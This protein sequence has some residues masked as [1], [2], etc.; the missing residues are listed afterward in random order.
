MVGGT[1]FPCCWYALF[2]PAFFFPFSL[3]WF[4][5]IFDPS[6]TPFYSFVP[7]TSSKVVQSLKSSMIQPPCHHKT[8]MSWCTTKASQLTRLAAG[9]K[10]THRSSSCDSWPTQPGVVAKVSSRLT[11]PTRYGLVRTMS[12][13][14]NLCWPLQMRKKRSSWSFS[15]FFTSP[16]HPMAAAVPF[17]APANTTPNLDCARNQGDAA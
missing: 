6:F 4:T 5:P 10:G 13:T 9:S 17:S 7:P 1:D 16:T 8:G 3:H 15:C 11:L 12:T 14:R 2:Q